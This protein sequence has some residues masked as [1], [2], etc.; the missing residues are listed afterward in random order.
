MRHAERLEASYEAL[1]QPGLHAQGGRAQDDHVQWKVRRAVGVPQPLDGLG[2][3]GNLLDLVEHQHGAGWGL[4]GFP[5]RRLP[6]PY[7]PVGVACAG[8]IQGIHERCVRQRVQ[9][10][11]VACVRR[12]VA[13]R[14]T[15]PLQRLSDD[16]RLAGLPRPED[17]LDQPR[18]GLQTLAEDFDLGAVEV[19][20]Q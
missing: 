7:Q 13:P 17:G 5:A 19:H 12:V 6:A 20:T 15:D 10:P 4:L 8:D 11:V 9:R 16:R 2:P 1:A 14:Q 3:P 18:P